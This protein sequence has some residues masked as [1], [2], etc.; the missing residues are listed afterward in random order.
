MSLLG[1]CTIF[2]GDNTGRAEVI[3]MEILDVNAISPCDAQRDRQ[4]NR[5]L[6]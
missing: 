2:V 4:A 5:K 1:N 6:E 3:G